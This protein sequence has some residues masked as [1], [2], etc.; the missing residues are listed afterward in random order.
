MKT[1]MQSGYGVPVAII[2]ASLLVAGAVF[3]SGKGEGAASNTIS[4]NI[5]E[6]Q[7]TEFRMPDDSDHVRGNPEGAIAIVEFSDLE[8]PFCARIHHT[9][10]RI[11]DENEDVKWV[12]R[13][14]PLSTIH[15]RALSAAVASEC[16]AQLGGND[17]FWKFTDEAFAN[18]RQLGNAWYREMA[19]SFGI[20]SEAF[21]SCL[22]DKSIVADIQKDLSEAT[23]TGGRGTP[24]VVV[25]TTNG[26]LI[27]F[28]GALP[29][30]N[31]VG[32]I[33]RAR[34]N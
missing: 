27:P 3:W 12:F 31:V 25:V 34:N 23:G 7:N 20:D 33:E 10:A 9:L 21:T 30:E 15:S 16:I 8:C 19:Q 32:L 29:Y 22:N 18:Q 11:V 17:A 4:D 5:E 6:R 14:F 1:S 28:S 2:I 13:H 26:K 24:Y